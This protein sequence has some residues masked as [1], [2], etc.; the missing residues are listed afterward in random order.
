MN[1]KTYTKIFLKQ[2][3][4][5]TSDNSVEQHYKLW[6]QNTRSKETEGF[7]LTDLGFDTLNQIGITFYDI[8][9]PEGMTLSSQVVIYLDKFIDTPYYIT[10]KNIFVTGEKKAVEL[11]LFA[12]D[13]RKFGVAK[14]LTRSRKNENQG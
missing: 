5:D 14:A 10:K 13:I 3:G 2:L 8:Q 11:S 7:R 4:R 9:F 6:W 1:K 12:G